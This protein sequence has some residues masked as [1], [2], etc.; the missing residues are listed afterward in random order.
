MLCGIAAAAHS[1]PSPSA[2]SSCWIVL[3]R[4]PFPPT[5]SCSQRGMR[6]RYPYAPTC[7]EWAHVGFAGRTVPQRR[8]ETRGERDAS[9]GTRVLSRWWHTHPQVRRG[10]REERSGLQPVNA[11]ILIQQ[12]GH[13]VAAVDAPCRKLCRQTRKTSGTTD[14]PDFEKS[15]ARGRC[16]ACGRMVRAPRE[17]PTSVMS[18]SPGLAATRAL[19]SSASR[20]PPSSTPSYVDVLRK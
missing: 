10:C 12:E 13:R 11:V 15:G 20:L 14:E 4:T 9:C 8:C 16:G 1:S 5:P 7:E 2:R 3:P 6:P 19:I 17:F 18:V